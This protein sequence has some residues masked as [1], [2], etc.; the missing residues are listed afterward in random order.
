MQAVPLHSCCP[1]DVAVA[2]FPDAAAGKHAPTPGSLQGRASRSACRTVG[3]SPLVPAFAC[4]ALHAVHTQP[5]CAHPPS[6]Y[7]TAAEH[8][9]SAV[10]LVN[11]TSPAEGN[12]E[13]Q[14]AGAVWAPVC[15]WGGNYDGG[16]VMSDPRVSPPPQLEA[17]GVLCRALG[18]P[19]GVMLPSNAFG[20][21]PS[22]S[23][24]D[25]L[26][27]IVCHGNESSPSGCDTSKLISAP[28]WER[29]MQTV[30]SLA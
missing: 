10:R 8:S 18:F 17:S 9:I 20:T 11:G 12:V 26:P 22:Y 13:L 21:L 24:R 19:A 16:L 23:N 30:A 1:Q 5:G 15:G 25:V 28:C 14:L 29:Y 6:L 3:T 2:C 4:M 27:G 7:C